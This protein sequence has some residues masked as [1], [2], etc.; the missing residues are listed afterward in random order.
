MHSEVTSVRRDQKVV[1]KEKKSFSIIVSIVHVR[2]E[3]YLSI[4]VQ[5]F[6]LFKMVYK[7]RKMR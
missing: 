3:A 6:F 1:T 7:T 4:L 5:N 2:T